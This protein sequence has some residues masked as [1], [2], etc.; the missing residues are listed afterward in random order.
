MSFAHNSDPCLQSGQL[1]D[2]AAALAVH[3]AAEQKDQAVQMMDLFSVETWLNSLY[4]TLK[5]F[6]T[7][8]QINQSQVIKKN[9]FRFCL[10]GGRFTNRLV[11]FLFLC[12]NL[13]S[14]SYYLQPPRSTILQEINMH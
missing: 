1:I 6:D 5:K 8:Y 12:Y 14:P 3:W 4:Q 7:R 13:S 11:L 2:A 10:E 9:R